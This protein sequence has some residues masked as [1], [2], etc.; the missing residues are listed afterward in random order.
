MNGGARVDAI[1]YQSRGIYSV[2]YSALL[3]AY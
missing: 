3:A 2:G 1:Q